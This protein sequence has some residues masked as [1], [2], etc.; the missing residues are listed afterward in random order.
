M[1]STFQYPLNIDGTTRDIPLWHK[2]EPHAFELLVVGER[3]Q[4][5]AQRSGIAK[6]KHVVAGR[7]H[8]KDALVLFCGA[9]WR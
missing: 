5:V 3:G 7:V 4:R 8:G 1:S 2:C 9:E 6:G